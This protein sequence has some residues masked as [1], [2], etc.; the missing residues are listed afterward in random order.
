MLLLHRKANQSIVIHKHGEAD[1]PLVM[2]IVEVFPTGDVTVG[3]MG[4]DYQVIRNEIFKTRLTEK[5]SSN[6]DI[7]IEKEQ[8]NEELI[9]GYFS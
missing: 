5:E 4:D 7:D 6:E 9:N 3:F 2:R 8:F 1:K